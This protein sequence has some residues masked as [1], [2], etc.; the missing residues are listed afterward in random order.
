MAATGAEQEFKVEATGGGDGSI[1]FLAFPVVVLERKD[2]KVFRSR[3][4]RWLHSIL[5]R[6][7]TIHPSTY[8]LRFPFLLLLLS[9]EVSGHSQ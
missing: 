6:R 8:Y 7:S 3:F 2:L 1:D 5:E 9:A 4:D